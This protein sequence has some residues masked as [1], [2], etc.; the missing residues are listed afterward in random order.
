MGRSRIRTTAVALSFEWAYVELALAVVSASWATAS[1]SLS[2]FLA[3]FEGMKRLAQVLVWVDLTS[4]GQYT[5]TMR[6]PSALSHTSPSII[7]SI[8]ANLLAFLRQSNQ[9]QQHI[10]FGSSNP[11]LACTFLASREH[12]LQDPALQILA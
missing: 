4:H 9:C 1:C 7:Y 6:I 10:E 11:G 2:S 3:L 5:Q 12:L 8:Q